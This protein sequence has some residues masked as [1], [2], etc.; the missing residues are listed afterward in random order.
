MV[1]TLKVGTRHMLAYVIL[2][3]D[4]PFRVYVCICSFSRLRCLQEESASKEAAFQHYIKELEVKGQ[5]DL[6]ETQE[7]CRIRETRVAELETC[8]EELRR[9]LQD[10]E[11]SQGADRE[12]Q[13]Q[14]ME[15]LKQEGAK[16]K[17]ANV[18]ISGSLLARPRDRVYFHACNN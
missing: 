5:A 11:A 15:R 7:L 6:A 12:T 1:Q 2:W 14:E 4:V 17:N 13:L 16:L 9:R 18:S 3:V 10:R 8:L